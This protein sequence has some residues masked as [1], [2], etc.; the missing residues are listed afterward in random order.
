MSYFRYHLFFCTNRREDGAPCCTQH[1]AVNMRGY[2][3]ERVKRLGLAGPGGIRVNTAGCLDRC[4]KGPVIVV[5]P[6][7]V[8]YTFVDREDIDEILEKHLVNGEIVERLLLK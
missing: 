8:W 1:G 2:L 3:K 6:E 4:E 5:Y 7:G